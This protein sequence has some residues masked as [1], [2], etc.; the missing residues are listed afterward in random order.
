MTPFEPEVLTLIE[1]YRNHAQDLYRAAAVLKSKTCRTL[2]GL[3]P[4][5]PCAKLRIRIASPNRPGRVQSPPPLWMPVTVADACSELR[6]QSAQRSGAIPVKLGLL[7]GKQSDLAPT[8]FRSGRPCRICPAWH[9]PKHAA[10]AL[11]SKRLPPMRPCNGKLLRHPFQDLG[12]RR[13]RD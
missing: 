7:A 8:P 5:V 1:A 9:Q 4:T 13:R 6:R 10:Y 3:S 11:M 2:D 12:M